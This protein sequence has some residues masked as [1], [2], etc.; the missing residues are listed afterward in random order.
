[1]ALMIKMVLSVYC[2]ILCLSRWTN[3]DNALVHSCMWPTSG[4]S[5][6][7]S[8]IECYFNLGLDYSEIPSFLLLVLRIQLTRQFK[9]VLLSKWLCRR[10]ITASLGFLSSPQSKIEV[11][12]SRRIMLRIP[13]CKRNTCIR[14]HYQCSIHVKGIKWNR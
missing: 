6:R 13:W 2:F 9:K 10:K 5:D 12:F 14:R 1:M 4:N 7:N 11:T 8:L 3:T